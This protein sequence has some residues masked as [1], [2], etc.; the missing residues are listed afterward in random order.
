MEARFG[1]WAVEWLSSSFRHLGLAERTCRGLVLEG[2][3]VT[4]E[5]W[6]ERLWCALWKGEA[7]ECGVGGLRC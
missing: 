6:R 4:G 7:V 2:E 1:V 3:G 5:R